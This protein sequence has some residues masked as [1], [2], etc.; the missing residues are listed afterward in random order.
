MVTLEQMTTKE[1][2]IICDMC[3]KEIPKQLPNSCTPG[4]AFIGEDKKICHACCGEMDKKT[5]E[6][7]DRI[8]LYLVKKDGKSFITNW[9]GTLSIRV[10]HIREGRHN[11]AGKRVTVWFTDHRNEQ[12][13]GIN[14]GDHTQICHCRKMKGRK[15]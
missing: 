8:A 11:I 2:Q 4:Y 13:Y 6:E 5:M 7:H 10:S 12:W 9:P 15:E 1:E 14:Y 3:K